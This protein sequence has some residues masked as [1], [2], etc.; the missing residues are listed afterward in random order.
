MSERETGVSVAVNSQDNDFIS[1]GSLRE[2]EAT[3]NFL[4]CL[5]AEASVNKPITCKK[6]K[7]KKPKL[8]H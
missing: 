7:K 5:M 1:F 2:I 4:L 3:K 6:K 8:L